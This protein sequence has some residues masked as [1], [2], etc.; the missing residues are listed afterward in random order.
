M[1]VNDSGIRFDLFSPLKKDGFMGHGRVNMLCK[2][3]G[4]IPFSFEHIANEDGLVAD[5]IPV[6]KTWCQLV[7]STISGIPI[8]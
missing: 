3:L 5:R 2:N 4:P 6:G 7:N 8:K 1:M